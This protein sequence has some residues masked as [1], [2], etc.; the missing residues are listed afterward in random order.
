M[1]RVYIK[2][3]PKQL[4][5]FN[6]I[7]SVLSAINAVC[8]DR[9]LKRAAQ[10]L[11]DLELVKY[12]ISNNFRHQGIKERILPINLFFVLK[13]YTWDSSPLSSQTSPTSST[14]TLSPEKIPGRVQGRGVV[15][16]VYYPGVVYKDLRIV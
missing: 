11:V 10:H 12:A 2:V 4:I 3:V 1:H 8:G 16:I 9:S 6:L 15:A 7:D 13:L 14:D 5:L